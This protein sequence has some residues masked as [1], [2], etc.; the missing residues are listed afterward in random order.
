[1]KSPEQLNRELEEKKKSLQG[2]ARYS[3]IA[4]QMFA[5][6]GLGIFA[7]YKL[8]EWIL[9]GIPVFTVIFSLLSVT[10]AIYLVVKDLLKDK[11]K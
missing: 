4:F 6:I 2:Y 9:G 5:I 8:D 10:G 11:K 3:S 1:M 7:G